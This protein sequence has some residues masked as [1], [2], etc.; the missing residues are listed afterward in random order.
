MLV[1]SS[2]R[3]RPTASKPN[4]PPQ[5]KIL[6]SAASAFH[7]HNIPHLQTHVRQARGLPALAAHGGLRLGSTPHHTYAHTPVAP[8]CRCRSCMCQTRVRQSFPAASRRSGCWSVHCCPMAAQSC[9]SGT[10]SRRASWLQRAA[11]ARPERCGSAVEAEG[12]RAMGG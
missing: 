10:P 1:H 7:I 8:G 3:H 11:H 6:Y 5:L 4:R 9:A 2:W 12:R